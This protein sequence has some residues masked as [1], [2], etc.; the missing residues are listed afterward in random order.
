MYVRPNFDYGDIVYHKP[1]DCASV[2]NE[3]LDPL[4]NQIEQLQYE[5]A[6]VITGAW[7]GTNS[8]KIYVE[9]GWESLH[10]RR[11]YRRATQFFKIM[12]GFT[13]QYLVD[14]IPVPRR[15]LFGRHITNDLYEFS[16]RNQ[17]FLNSFYPD[18]VLCWNSLGP[19]IRNLETLSS[20]KNKL[21]GIIKPMPRSIFKIHNPNGVRFLYQLRV[22][23]SSLREHKK[24]HKFLDTPS[25]I[26]HCG[27]GVETTEHFLL[28]CPLFAGPRMDLPSTINPKINSKF[29][30]EQLIDSDLVQIILY[31]NEKFNP[32]E[33]NSILCATIDY[34]TSTDRF[35]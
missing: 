7:K 2:S 27:T 1:N 30:N 23:L 9:L 11:W 14:P 10:H 20:F 25:D 24:R 31:G 32:S 13:P 22:G 16:Y 6:R 29:Q 34:I 4:M 35:S 15:H 26:C 12:N 33:N 3:N 5:A 17:R 21:L 8:S 18:S 19:E 28:K